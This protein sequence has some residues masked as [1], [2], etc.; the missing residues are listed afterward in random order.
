[1]MSKRIPLLL[2]LV[3]DARGDASHAISN[4][5]RSK[6]FELDSHV[7]KLVER[8]YSVDPHTHESWRTLAAFWRRVA[9]QISCEK[10]GIGPSG[11]FCMN[12][13]ETVKSGVGGN[14]CMNTKLTDFL[15][16][17]LLA[18]KAVLDVGCGLGQY[19]RYLTDQRSDLNVQWAGIDGSEDIEA[20]T[21]GFVKFADLTDGLPHFA[22]KPW[23]WVMSIE[24]A[25]HV[26]L[27]HEGS[28]LYNVVSWAR[29]GVILSWAVPS[30]GGHFHVNCQPERYVDCMMD[31][32]GFAPMKMQRDAARSAVRTNGQCMWLSNTIMIFKRI[33]SI[34]SGG[35][36]R[37][38]TPS[39]AWL[40]WYE[41]QADKCHRVYNGCRTT[42]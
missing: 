17:N 10:Q 39:K 16:E 33:Q 5:W 25:E 29:E 32:L 38:A 41:R 26:P 30:Q 40:E 7:A 34:T 27:K 12:A 19:G 13:S 42:G 20:Y 23:D 14:G 8:I 4:R 35:E 2:L 9:G 22:Q 18:S 24:V 21:R 15:A 36:M 6:A 37:S 1:M 31:K 28:F 11:G 3:A